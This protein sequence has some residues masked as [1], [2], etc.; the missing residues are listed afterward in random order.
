MKVKIRKTATGASNNHS[1]RGKY[2]NVQRE[3][4]SSPIGDK[5]VQIE[6]LVFRFAAN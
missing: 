1:R 6:V 4:P 5:T 3:S 2:L